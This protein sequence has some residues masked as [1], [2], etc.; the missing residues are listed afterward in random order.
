LG[1]LARPQARRA[2]VVLAAGAASDEP[3]LGVLLLGDI[4]AV[5]D[6]HKAQRIATGDLIRYLSQVDESPWG[7]WWLDKEGEPNR[8]GPRRLAQLLRPFGIRSNST[9]R[10]GERTAK[11]YRREDFL[12]TWERFLAGPRERCARELRCADIDRR[13]ALYREL[14]ERA[15]ETR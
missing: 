1:A 3:S 7:E 10:I 5:F 15:R 13:A 8:G 9:V 2:A 14:T 11:G 6:E 12:D 4:R